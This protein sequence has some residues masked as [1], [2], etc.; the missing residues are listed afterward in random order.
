MK[1]SSNLSFSLIARMRGSC[2]SA[3]MDSKAI[4]RRNLELLIDEA[5]R[6]KDLAALI[7]SD[8][9]Y[10]SVLRGGHRGIGDDIARRLENACSKPHGWMDHI[11]DLEGRA[12]TEEAIEEVIAL[13]SAPDHIR[14]A[15]RRMLSPQLSRR[16]QH[17]AIN[18]DSG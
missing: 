8:P 11:H 16:R 5:G 10:L 18:R 2:C 7:D 9:N 17:P 15:V 6:L 4:R 13:Q 3:R 14:D 12:L 1:A